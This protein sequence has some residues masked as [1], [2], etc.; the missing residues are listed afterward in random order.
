MVDNQSVAIGGHCASSQTDF[1][2]PVHCILGLP[3]DAVNT[4]EVM[5]RIWTASDSSRC[6]LSTPN[7]NFLIASQKNAAFRDS[8]LRSDLSIADGMPLVW[9]ASLLG[10]PIRE[11]VAGSDVFEALSNG[12]GAQIKVY[13][14]G[15]ADG[16]A[17][18]AS[19]RLNALAQ[20]NLR[21]V[22]YASPGFG[23]IEQMSDPD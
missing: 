19:D 12:A 3:F 22:G 4:S 1:R 10:I 16:V 11:R 17:K 6:F 20:S 9:I 18:Q 8:I 15:G 13:F 5:H 14:F 2:R 7:L 21:C 23:S